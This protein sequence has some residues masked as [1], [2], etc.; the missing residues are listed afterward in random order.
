VIVVD[1]SVFVDFFRGTGSAAADRMHH[2]EEEDVPF[3][4]PAICCQ[5]LLQ[6]ARD[7]RE[8]RLLRDYLETQ[9][10]LSPVEAWATHAAAAR[11]FYDCRR[12]GITI[13]STIDCL[14]AQLV[15]ENDGVLLHQDEDFE[16]IR[17]VRPLRTLGE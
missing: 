7:E 3:A 14:I 17:A 5:E 6:G 10:I 1:T 4:I 12:Q 16:R 11:I 13:R 2:L 9:M 8:W 15:L